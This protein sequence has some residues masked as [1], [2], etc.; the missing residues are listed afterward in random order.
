MK[1]IRT[2]TTVF[3]L[4]VLIH[5]GL[6]GQSV[7]EPPA[8]KQGNELPPIKAQ[9][10]TTDRDFVKGQNT[11]IRC[12]ILLKENVSLNLNDLKNI[13]TK[14]F[15]VLE[16]STTSPV[17][18]PGQKDYRIISV[19]EV[20]K[21]NL[22]LK[23]GQYSFKLSLS[24]TYP[25]INWKENDGKKILETKVISKTE[26]FPLIV[27]EKKPITARVDNGEGFQNVV[28]IGEH[29]K[30]SLHIF[31]E[32]DAVFLLND[33]SPIELDKKYGIRDSTKLDNPD[34]KPFIVINK[35]DQHKKKEVHRGYHQ[36]LIYEYRLAL[37]E[38]SLVKTF[39]I[40]TIKIY[41]ATRNENK[42]TAIITPVIKIRT[43][44]VLNQDS[45]FR[46]LKNIFESDPDKSLHRGLWPLR[47]AYTLA[48]LAGLI[49]FY[50]F[51]AF[52]IRRIKKIYKT[53][54]RATIVEIKK[55]IIIKLNGLPYVALV[56]TR[57]A[58]DKF[59]AKPN[60]K[61]LK[62][63]ITC[64][65]LYFGA[66]VKIPPNLALSYTAAEFCAKKINNTETLEIAEYLLD[67]DVTEQDLK[68]LE[69]KFK[70][71]DKKI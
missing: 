43:N 46:P 52:T 35:D 25:E 47:A 61:N 60:K 71:S 3:W 2:V 10:K 67:E 45:E 59:K 56:K 26:N 38:I 33:Q 29:I 1:W 30:Y 37:Y 40:P 49:V 19:L 51:L 13:A 50:A 8:Q 48:I 6:N 21:P 17:P 34:L 22:A 14:D 5:L 36:E 69:T 24:Y 39:E 53:G 20:L 55:S 16:L 44:S 62:I 23:Y 64:L 7:P 58:L 65:R 54:L 57:K 12:T 27:F 31:Y 41:Y 15:S 68:I 9:C 63:F 4:T 18:V 32:K 70:E 11:E 42:A 66:L 28:N